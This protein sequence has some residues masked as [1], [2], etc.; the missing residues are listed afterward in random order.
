MAPPSFEIEGNPGNIRAKAV[1]MEQKGQL[2]YD[3]AARG[4]TPCG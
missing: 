3:T 4:S 2:F 1:L